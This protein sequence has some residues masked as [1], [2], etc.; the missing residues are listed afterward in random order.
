MTEK[1]IKKASTGGPKL[2]T[3]LS[4]TL[5]RAPPL[6]VQK[7]SQDGWDRN[8][9][10]P[11]PQ[12]LS[13]VSFK[14]TY[15]QGQ[16]HGGGGRNSSNVGAWGNPWPSAPVPYKCLSPEEKKKNGCLLVRPFSVL[17][18]YLVEHCDKCCAPFKAKGLWVEDADASQAWRPQD[19]RPKCKKN[20]VHRALSQPLSCVSR[21]VTI[22]RGWAHLWHCKNSAPCNCDAGI[23]PS[24]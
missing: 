11:Q 5:I 17:V 20:L 15:S 18:I 24:R 19:L 2:N 22:D 13:K 23:N 12:Q 10:R 7:T 21:H 16:H 14:E 9:G 4:I 3:A 1:E 6:K 8:Q